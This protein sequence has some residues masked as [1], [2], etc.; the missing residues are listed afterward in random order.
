MGHNVWSRAYHEPELR[1]WLFRQ[2]RR[3]E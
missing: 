1:D 2:H 3:A